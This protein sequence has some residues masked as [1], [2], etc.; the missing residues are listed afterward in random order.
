MRQFTIKAPDDVGAI[1]DVYC[2]RDPEM[3]YNRFFR[4]AVREKAERDGV[5]VPCPA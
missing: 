4:E 5:A 3:T 2:E 1:V